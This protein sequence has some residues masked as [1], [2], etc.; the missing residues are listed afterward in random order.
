MKVGNGVSGGGMRGYIRIG[1]VDGSG[2]TGDSIVGRWSGI[3]CGVSSGVRSG[4]LT[5]R[6]QSFV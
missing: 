6:V 5:G 1:W 2:I 3:C 4:A